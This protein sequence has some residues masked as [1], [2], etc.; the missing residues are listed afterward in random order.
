M[1]RAYLHQECLKERGTM[2]GTRRC[3]YCRGRLV[4]D[5]PDTTRW[6]NCASCGERFFL[7]DDGKLVSPFARK[8]LNGG[9]MCEACGRSLAGGVYTAP[10]E[11]GNNPDGYIKCP[12]CGHA[13]FI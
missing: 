1:L 10:W 6:F 8:Q 12:H 11:N 4:G 3:P 9:R 7:Q 2:M 5:A 13:N